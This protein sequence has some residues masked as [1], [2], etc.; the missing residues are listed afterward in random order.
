MITTGWH[1]VDTADG[2]M[3][4]WSA[5][6][7]DRSAKGT[8]RVLQEAFG[9]NP[10]IQ[11]VTRR[12]AA[13]GYHAVAPDL[14]HRTGVEVLRYDEYA[15]AMTLIGDIG[16]EQIVA[17]V[18]AALLFAGQARA[19]VIGFCFGGRAAFTAAIAVPGLSA[20]V[21]FYGPGIAAGAHAV[22]DRASSI[23]APVLL[24][25]GAEDPSIPAEQVAA[26]EE[27]LRK[28]AVRFES[29]VYPGAGHAFACDAR[30]DRF[31]PEAA[32]QAWQRTYRFLEEN[33]GSSGAAAE[34]RSGG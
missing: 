30:P 27:A 33:L 18:C 10:Q 29:H 21:V 7:G 26:T 19:A 3:R 25:N 5:A 11:Y 16:A 9:V 13:E 23:T 24:H 8:V 31:H 28:A 14:F 1:A 12:L 15:K 32:R 22:L 34:P 4:V 17:D 20:T 6:P 2:P